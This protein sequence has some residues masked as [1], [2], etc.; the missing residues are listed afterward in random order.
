M[1]FHKKS[2]QESRGAVLSA[3]SILNDRLVSL[4]SSQQTRLKRWCFVPV[5]A[6]ILFCPGIE[7]LNLVLAGNGYQESQ[8]NHWEVAKRHKKI[9]KIMES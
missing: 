6:M 8:E 4:R 3:H 7:M 9:A 2:P 1:H 5:A